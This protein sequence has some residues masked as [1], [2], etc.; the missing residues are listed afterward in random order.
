MLCKFACECFNKHQKGGAEPLGKGQTFQGCVAAKIAEECY[1]GRYPKPDSNVWREVPYDRGKD[2]D[3]IGSQHD[4]NVPTSQYIRPDSRRP[5]VVWRDAATG[6][7]KKFF[8]MK[9]PGDPSGGGKM[10]SKRLDEYKEIADKH[11]GDKDNYEEFDVSE[12]CK[13]CLEPAPEPEKAPA[14]A[15]A[16][17]G[18]SA[19]EPESTLERVIVTAK[20]AATPMNVGL[21]ALSLVAA[22]VIVVFAGPIVAAVAGF[23]GLAVAVG[24]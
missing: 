20:R 8:D 24:G 4:P 11:T 23:L 18:E 10:D 16:P 7:I 21:V 13:G 9:F 5:D 14:P 17:T 12:R 1:D 6:A 15:P 19:A 22:A 3:M 2:W